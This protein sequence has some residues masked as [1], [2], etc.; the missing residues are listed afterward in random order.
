MLKKLSFFSGLKRITTSNKYI[1]EIDGIRFVA[2]LLVVLH[3]I[4]YYVQYKDTNTYID[5]SLKCFLKKILISGQ[6]GVE[7]FFVLSGF[8]LS[9]PFASHFLIKA[10]MPSLK[11]F[12]TRRLTR[13]EPPYI[14]M[15]TLLG[16][17]LFFMHK[18]SGAVLLKSYLASITY[19]H[20]IFYPGMASIING[21][22]WSL[23]IEFQFYLIAPFLCYI[24]FLQKVSRRI[25]IL[26]CIVL[27]IIL[28]SL[29]I[30]KTVSLLYFLQYFLLGFLVSDLYIT[31]DYKSV[32]N[33]FSIPLGILSII[34]ILLIPDV[35]T[36]T[37]LEL[38]EAKFYLILSISLFFYIAMFSPFWK[39][40]LS[41]SFVSTIG[42]M[43]YSIYLFHF[44]VIDLI[45]KQ[46]VKRLHFSNYFIVHY[47]V[48]NICLLTVILFTS[49]AF[50]K[51]IEQP[52]MKADW[53]LIL[54]NKIR[55]SAPQS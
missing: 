30:A 42:G 7:I 45:G 23:E 35:K 18:F 39:K 17:T 53:Y 33:V 34:L 16:M 46:L 40:I 10:E 25:L 50:Y 54:W 32:K 24:F 48:I 2:I 22:A 8:V 44:P 6:F 29:F 51:L 3:H 37:G 19:T 41:I 5:E 1:P 11:K 13:L 21:I 26:V 20:F 36:I 55:K 12:Y 38:L 4:S 9:I 31:K 15:L 28:Q 14:L 52:C 27:L 49:S 43:C 47:L